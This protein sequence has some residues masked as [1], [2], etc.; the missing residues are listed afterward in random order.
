MEWCRGLFDAWTKFVVVTQIIYLEFEV[1]ISILHNFLILNIAA[2]ESHSSSFM[3][4]FFKKCVTLMVCLT[5]RVM[6][7]CRCMPRIF[8]LDSLLMSS[9]NFLLINTKTFLETYRTVCDRTH[10]CR[11]N[12]CCACVFVRPLQMTPTLVNTQFWLHIP[13]VLNVFICMNH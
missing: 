12:K 11:F 6:G 9:A 10:F 2:V 3:I 7:W 13:F 5:L 8:L 1:F 4:F